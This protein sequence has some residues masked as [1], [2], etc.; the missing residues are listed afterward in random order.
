MHAFA[1]W[2]AARSV[3]LFFPRETFPAFFF[4]S[5]AQAEYHFLERPIV[6]GALREIEK[7]VRIQ[8]QCN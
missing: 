5:I 1:W 6:H 4:G 2:V 7:R 3:N 8:P